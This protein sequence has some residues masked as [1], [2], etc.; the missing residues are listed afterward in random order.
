[1]SPLHDVIQQLLVLDRQRPRKDGV[2]GDRGLIEKLLVTVDA[3][4]VLLSYVDSEERYRFC[5]RSYERWFGVKREAV[6]GRSVLE[7]LGPAAYESLLPKVRAALAGQ[8][9]RFER[10]VPYREGGTRVVQAEYLPHVEEDGHVAGFVAMVSDVTELRA[11][12]EAGRLAHQLRESEDRLRLAIEAAA[13]GTWDQALAQGPC[14]LNERSRE[15][16]GLPLG[17]PLDAERLLGCV[18]EGDRA[19]V[20]AALRAAFDPAGDGG[21]HLEFRARGPLSREERWLSAY[22]RVHFDAG[23]RPLRFSGVLQDVT[24]DRRARQRADRLAAVSAALSQAL[25]PGEVAG[26]VVREGAAALE[27]VSASLVLVSGDG[28]AFELCAAHGFPEGSLEGWR[29]FPL[30]TPVMY[31]DAVRTGRPVL[32]E[33]LPAFLRDYPGLEGASSLLG[34]AFAALPL[35]VGSRV[36]GAFGF[37]FEREQSFSPEQLQFMEALGQQCALALERSRLYAAERQARAEAEELRDSLAV[38]RG[39]LDAVLSQ[40]PVAVIIAAP[41]GHLIRGNAAVESLWG[42]PYVAAPDIAGYSAYKGFRPDGTPYA[43]EQW[44][45]ARSL[46]HGETVTNEPVVIQREDGGTRHLE[47][48]ARRVTDARGQ[49]LAAM[50]VS[51]DVTVHHEMRDALQREAEVRDRLMGIVGHD[52]RNP[53]QAI[54]TSSSL[55]LRE[56]VPGSTQ[57]K[58]ATRILTSVRRMDHLIRDLLDY[59]RASRG[60]MLPIQCRRVSLEDACR[61]AMEELLAAWPERSIHLEPRGDLE[62]DWDLDRLIQ[63]VG[64]LLSNALTHGARDVPVQVR[65]DGTGP[66]AVLEVAN[67]GDPIPPALLPRIFQPFT[68]AA[69]GGDALKGVGLGLFIVHEIATAHGGRIAVTSTAEEGTVFRVTLPRGRGEPR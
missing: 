52:L 27:A 60:G 42:Q 28:T 65:V 29:R 63:L 68:R 34:R 46:L 6:L 10:A 51:M 59:A 53:L 64:N 43:A 12:E 49:L 1:M 21:L 47:L 61:A 69:A 17:P 56:S 30:D 4:P 14:N 9:V 45:L 36:I 55:L 18:H 13:L 40:L 16:L 7:V 39:L 2:L 54:A 23:W 20:E 5:N 50:A 58:R 15:L 48:S 26:T 25:L 11:G 66:E 67:Q 62:G 37:S 44:P 35:K 19:R 41:D 33:D 22:G 24:E 57:H 32:Y 8:P 3:A 38:E 31:R